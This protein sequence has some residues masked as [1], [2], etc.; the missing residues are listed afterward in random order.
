MG[1]DRALFSGA[2]EQTKSDIESVRTLGANEPFFG[3]TLS[4]DTQTSQA[5][6]V[7]PER[8]RRLI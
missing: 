6:L 8:I 7:S 1:A 5:L 2:L 4:P 3:P